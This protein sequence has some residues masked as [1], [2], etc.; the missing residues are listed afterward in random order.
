MDSR[1]Q[2][3]SYPLPEEKHLSVKPKE[4][5]VKIETVYSGEIVPPLGDVP[6]L[7]INTKNHTLWFTLP[8]MVG[9]HS[10]KV[11]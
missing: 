9:W 2:A 3:G 5:M 10:V 1:R 8:G 4:E 7:W 6:A 11:K